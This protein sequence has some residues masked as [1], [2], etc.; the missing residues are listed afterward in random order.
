MSVPEG[1]LWNTDLCSSA[2]MG[3]GHA[4]NDSA[5][6]NSADGI[7]NTPSNTP[8]SQWTTRNNPPKHAP[9][10]SPSI[11]LHR[12]PLPV[13][14]AALGGA[15]GAERRDAQVPHFGIAAAELGFVPWVGRDE[16]ALESSHTGECAV[17]VRARN[18]LQ[19]GVGA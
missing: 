11:R 15:L 3:V 18:L 8:L 7:S 16:L 14:G 12:R 1:L 17:E 2:L 13:L 10:Y 5:R 6:P 9:P 4:K 19:I